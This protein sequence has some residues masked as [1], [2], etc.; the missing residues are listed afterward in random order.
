MCLAGHDVLSGHLVLND[1]D[2][3]L[4]RRIDVNTLLAHWV[5][6]TDVVNFDIICLLD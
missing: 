1:V 3:L 4:L 2:A 5:M 6:I